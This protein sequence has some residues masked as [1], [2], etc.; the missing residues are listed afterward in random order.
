MIT[1]QQVQAKIAELEA[2][3]EDRD[4]D[5]IAYSEIIK[6]HQAAYNKQH[7]YY[8]DIF[9]SLVRVERMNE[10]LNELLRG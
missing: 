6:T 7:D 5:I 1:E 2:Y 8:R 9:V 4:R 3:I 10:K